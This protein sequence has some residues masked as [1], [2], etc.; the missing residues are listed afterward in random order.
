M[1]HN[2]LD[3]DLEANIDLG[4]RNKY[5]NKESAMLPIDLL[6]TN[7][8]ITQNLNFKTI[9]QWTSKL[10]SAILMVLILAVI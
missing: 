2:Y 8:S 10:K 9:I 3:A 6:D 1:F 7:N 4:D 5:I